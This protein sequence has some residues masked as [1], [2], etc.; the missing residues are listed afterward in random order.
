MKILNWLQTGWNN[1]FLDVTENMRPWF[2]WSFGILFTILVIVLG[3][4][5][6]G[7]LWIMVGL[8]EVCAILRKTTPW[9]RM[10]KVFTSFGKMFFK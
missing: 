6:V 9:K 10:T 3:I 1:V 7:P 2:K 5:M 8:D 4:A